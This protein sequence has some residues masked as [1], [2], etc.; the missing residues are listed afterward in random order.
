M[1]LRATVAGAATSATAVEPSRSGRST[2]WSDRQ[3]TRFRPWPA[4]CGVQHHQVRAG[5]VMSE[6]P[7]FMVAAAALISL[8]VLGCAL[9]IKSDRDVR[10]SDLPPSPAG[11]TPEEV[12]GAF[13]ALCQE[14]CVVAEVDRGTQALRFRRSTGA[15]VICRRA[16]AAV[17]IFEAFPARADGP[18]TGSAAP[19]PHHQD[20]SS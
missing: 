5:C 2:T 18:E 1:S 3:Q 11:L 16:G 12:A 7:W 10:Q 9:A 6:I 17:E 15:K 8:V 14:H 4:G 13:A 19:V 20:S